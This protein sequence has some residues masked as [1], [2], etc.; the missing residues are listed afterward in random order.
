MLCSSILLQAQNDSLAYRIS[1]EF[2]ASEKAQIEKSSIQ[3]KKADMFSDEASKLSDVKKALKLH[4]K[5]S[6]LYAEN[7][8]II[9]S[10]RK[11]KLDQ[12]KEKSDDIKET[13]FEYLYEQSVNSY[14]T[15]VSNRTKAENTKKPEEALTYFAGA[16]AENE[17]AVK[18]QDE[19]FAVYFDLIDFEQYNIA[20]DY[21]SEVM[22]RGEDS[23]IQQPDT[24]DVGFAEETFSTDGTFTVIQNYKPDTANGNNTRGTTDDKTNSADGNLYDKDV[25]FMVQVAASTRPIAPNAL[26]R[27]YS[28]TELRTE[29]DNGYYKYLFGTYSNYKEAYNAK[30]NSGVKGAFVVAYKDGKRIKSV[31]E[32]KSLAPESDV[33]TMKTNSGNTSSEVKTGNNATSELTATSDYEY[34]L[35]IGASRLPANDAQLK[36]MN[37]TDKQ[38]QVYKS[39]AFY[40]YT[41]GPFSNEAEAQACKNAYSLK[42]AIIVKYKNGKEAK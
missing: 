23:E 9:Y 6:K 13:A 34:R 14:R 41:V 7:Y 38:V 40:K 26:K 35:Q 2:S 33:K 19:S 12:L 22:S 18:Y 11:K 8:K 37:P 20:K 21:T 4:K 31:T 39:S 24:D 16:K 27:I 17:N 5:A 25:V 30:Q 1:S 28:K 3:I 10:L 36:A 15:A 29:R 32:F 42:G